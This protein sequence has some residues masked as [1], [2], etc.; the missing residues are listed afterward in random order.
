MERWSGLKKS[1]FKLLGLPVNCASLVD[2]DT[3]RS[4]SPGSVSCWGCH[5]STLYYRPTPMRESTLRIMARNDAL[6]LEDP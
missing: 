6:Y 3:L 2:H 4:A 5:A 1:A